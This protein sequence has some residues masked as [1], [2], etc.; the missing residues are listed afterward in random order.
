MVH[1]G[2]EY[3]DS[4]QLICEAYNLMKSGLGM[5]ADEN[6]V[7]KEWNEGD[8]DSYLI[9]ITR[10]ILGYKDENGGPLVEKIQI[11][12]LKAPANGP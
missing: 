12:P 3:G 4:A 10:D 8:L 6:A 2:I 5:S 7:F 11:Q 9:E 1:N